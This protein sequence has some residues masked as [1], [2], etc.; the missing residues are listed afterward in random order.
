MWTSLLLFG[1]RRKKR[2]TRRNK[3]TPMP[4]NQA[5]KV[6]RMVVRLVLRILSKL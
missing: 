6:D 3:V 2:P 5:N 1:L 4:I